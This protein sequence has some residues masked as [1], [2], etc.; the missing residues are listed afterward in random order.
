MRVLLGSCSLRLI[1]EPE[2]VWRLVDSLMPFCDWE[3]HVGNSI[4][5][6]VH[7]FCGVVV[8]RAEDSVARVWKC[9]ADFLLLRLQFM[10][11]GFEC[12]KTGSV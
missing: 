12:L 3:F 9:K 10:N 5:S 4:E 11:R 7:K 2:S 1:V 6:R 8:E